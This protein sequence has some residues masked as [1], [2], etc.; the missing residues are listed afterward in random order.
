MK[1]SDHPKFQ[2]FEIKQSWFEKIIS[3]I[4]IV[5]CFIWEYWIH[6]SC[7]IVSAFFMLK[8]IETGDIAFI[9]INLFIMLIGSMANSSRYRI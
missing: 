2:F 5:Y 4:D 7:F 9:L 1:L 3:F 6:I 8:Y